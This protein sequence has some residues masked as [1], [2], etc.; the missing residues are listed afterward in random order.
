MA[1]IES[2]RPVPALIASPIVVTIDKAGVCPCCDSH[3]GAFAAQ[4]LSGRPRASL[5]AFPNLFTVNML[6]EFSVLF[7]RAAR[8]QNLLAKGWVQLA[9]KTV[10]R[11]F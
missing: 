11:R 1:R 9:G 2:F 10:G 4:L 6:A 8:P 5:T 7:V 3:F